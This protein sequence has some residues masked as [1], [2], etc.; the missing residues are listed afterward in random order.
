MLTADLEPVQA[1]LQEKILR[2]AG[3]LGYGTE[4]VEPIYDGVADAAAYHDAKPRLMW[5][6]ASAS[7]RACSA[8]G[9]GGFRHRGGAV[10]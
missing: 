7:R 10:R 8:R 3:E 5:I 6:L 4:K 9:M 1:A 2:R